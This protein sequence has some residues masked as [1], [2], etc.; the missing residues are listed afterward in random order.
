MGH[1]GMA[2]MRGAW[3][4]MGYNI[5]KIMPFPLARTTGVVII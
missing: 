2:Y 5:P 1:C 4:G 3:T